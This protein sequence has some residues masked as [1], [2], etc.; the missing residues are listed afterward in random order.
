[1]PRVGDVMKFLSCKTFAI[2]MFSCALSLPAMAH[3]GAPEAVRPLSE[4]MYPAA[5]HGGNYM[6]NYYFPPA[7]SSTPW[8]AV[9]S[10][11]G[12]FAAV[13]MAGSIWRVDPTTGNAE[14]LSYNEKYYS[15]PDWLPD[16]DWIV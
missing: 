16:G 1:M 12:Q 2:Y 10:P 3:W 6:H 8:A 7:P 15:S 4:R 9:W 11:D 5:R 13:S 14:E